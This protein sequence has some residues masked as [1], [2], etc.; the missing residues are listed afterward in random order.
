MESATRGTTPPVLSPPIRV[1]VVGSGYLG[2]THAACLA[3]C[4]HEVVGVDTDPERMAR[5]SEGRAPFHEPRLDALLGDGL[6]SGRLTFTTE[7]GRA[8]DATVHFLCVGTPQQA[9]SH[10][11]DLTAL[12]SATRTLARHL[13][14]PCLVVGKSTVP[15]GTAAQVRDV[16]HAEAPAGEAVQIAWNPEFLR[17]GHAVDDSLHPDRLVFGVESDQANQTLR[18]VYARVIETGVPVVRTDLA[19]AELAKVSANVM[20]AARVSLV[21]LLAEVCEAADADVGDLTEVL[22]L[23]RRIGADFLSPGIGY[24]GGCLPKDTRAFAAR[25]EELGLRGPVALLREVDSLNMRQRARTIDLAVELAGGS[26]VGTRVAVL[27][28][29]VKG[30]CDDVRDSPALDVATTLHARG[31][32][33]R[34]Y[35]PRA[36]AN[37]ARTVPSL[38]VAATVE[39]A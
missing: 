21:N 14:R 26:P 38:E 6:A 37:V 4:G 11:A 24:G 31:A 2:A 8:A 22:G 23:D 35:D 12:W 29:A 13:E 36:G 34:V 16:L 5:L 39:D 19:T 1:S 33:V 9:G 3:A 30:E 18:E 10:A 32:D 17:E 25:A 15:V 20:L 7:V 28:A 27:G